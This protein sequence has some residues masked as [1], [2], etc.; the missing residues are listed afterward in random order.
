MVF[1]GFVVAWRR[2]YH[3]VLMRHGHTTSSGWSR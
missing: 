2:Y 1:T 3:G